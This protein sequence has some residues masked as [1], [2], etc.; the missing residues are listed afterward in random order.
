MNKELLQKLYEPFNLKE[1]MG[2]GGKTFKYVPTRDVVD[3]MNKIFDGNWS[4]EVISDKLIE[5]QV[6]ILVRV[7]ITD[8]V[9]GK[10]YWQDGYDSHPVARFTSGPNVGK[11]V[12]IGNTYRS[13]MSKAIKTACSKWGVGLYLNGEPHT[14]DLYVSEIPFNV[15]SAATTK[16]MEQAAQEAKT[17]DVPGKKFNVPNI[18]NNTHSSSGPIIGDFQNTPP[19]ISNNT[20]PPTNA[21]PIEAQTVPEKLPENQKLNNNVPIFDNNSV[22]NTEKI[23]PVQK[24]AVE[25]VMKANNLS[26]QQLCA[27][28]LERENDLPLAID[29]VDYSDAVKMIQYRNDLGTST[30]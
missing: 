5:D 6:L 16:T 2:P 18:P 3:R 23:T 17:Y 15:D 10:M 28:A 14:E 22:T 13:A 20:L 8:P 1:R 24:V 7:M 29:D 21:P 19:I 12:D 11:P 9:S 26:F 4:T 30:S 25:T 27:L